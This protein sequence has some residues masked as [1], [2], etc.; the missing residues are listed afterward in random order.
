[1]IKN[2]IKDVKL[3][4][5]VSYLQYLCNGKRVLHL[6]ATDAPITIESVASKRLLHNHINE[7]SGYLVGLDINSEMIHWLSDSCGINSILYGD[8]ERPE[9][10]PKDNFDIIIAG[11]ILEHLSNPGKAL[12][13]IRANVQPYTKLVITVPNT[14]SF[15]GF[16]RAVFKYELIHPDHILHHSPHTLKV[17]L[18]R[19]G[20][21][22]ESYFSFVNGGSGTLASF[23]NL[24]LNF[25]PQL[26]EGIGIICS[27]SNSGLSS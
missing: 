7:V 23:T 24:F 11:E 4:D 25:Q 6:G 26:A 14:Y 1:M 5:R 22:V 3:V 8:I 27:P 13:S 16:C 17:L 18:Q 21:F 15:K 20:F 10:Y 9:H 19:H 12:D 2:Y